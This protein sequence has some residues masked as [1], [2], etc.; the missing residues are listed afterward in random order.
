[1]KF[2]KTVLKVL[3]FPVTLALTLLV[4]IGR[5]LT[6][7]SSVLLYIVAL[8]CFL[9]GRG[10]MIFLK[11]PF[12]RVWQMFL[13]AWLLSPYGLPF[14]AGFLIELLDVANGALKSL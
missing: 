8:V 1:M 13:M 5:M 2:L 6:R 11:E 9:I 12:A 4:S 14:L 3:L 7:F 10:S